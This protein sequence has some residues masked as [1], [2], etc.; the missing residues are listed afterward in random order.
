MFF[1]VLLVVMWFI[2]TTRAWLATTL[3]QLALSPA[4]GKSVGLG[5]EY[6]SPLLPVKQVLLTDKTTAFHHPRPSWEK[7]ILIIPRKQI[8]T[9]F[10]LLEQKGYLESIYNA[11]HTVFISEHFETES[12]S[13]TV[14]GG[15]RQDVKQVHFHLYQ[16]R[17]ALLEIKQRPVLQTEHFTVYEQSTQPLH[18]V[19]EP[20][21][22]LPPLSKWTK[23]HTKQLAALDLPLPELEQ[24]YSLSS[25]GF[26]LIFQEASGV[27]KELLT[28]H[29]TAGA[30]K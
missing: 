23:N 21:A 17:E 20:T 22:T 8:T 12:Y 6:A 29:L 24:V 16:P 15:L 2:P 9:I 27:E 26:S 28:I 30:L 3:F 25:R 10:D 13:L 7:H 4:M 1:I 19:L 5:F 18:L 14:N 11:A